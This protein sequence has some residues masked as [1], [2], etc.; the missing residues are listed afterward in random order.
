[1]RNFQEKTLFFVFAT[2]NFAGLGIFCTFAFEIAKSTKDETIKV[3]CIGIYD[4]ADGIVS[5]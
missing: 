3:N 4:A 5:R 1:L 2:Q